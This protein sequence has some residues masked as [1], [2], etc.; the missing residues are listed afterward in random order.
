[1]CKCHHK[2]SAV[3][4]GMSKKTLEIQEKTLFDN[5]LFKALFKLFFKIWFKLSGWSVTESNPSSAGITIAAPHTSNW[6][7]F[8]AL[9]AAVLIDV[10]IYFSI[11]ESWCR[12]PVVGGLILWLGGIPI[13]RSAGSKG[14]VEKI[15]GF[16]DAHKDSRIFF[17]F[18]PEG[19]RGKVKGW[20]S[21][22]YH[23]A[24]ACDL[25]VFLAKVDFRLKE[26]GVFHSY[27]LT[28]DKE[29]DMRAMQESYKKVCGCFPDDQYPVY[30]GPLPEISD[31]EALILEGIHSMKGFVTLMEI[32]AQTKR[33]ELS[34]AMLEFLVE[35]G[36]LEQ[37]DNTDGEPTY[38]L[39][40]AGEGCLL[41]LFPTLKLETQ[42]AV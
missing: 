38:Q 22:F 1:M 16:V 24:E 14:Q 17:L 31:V 39:S 20:K 35:K 6:D 7:I 32:E 12:T 4:I 28:G 5:F 3:G 21:G 9:G 18:T 23:M 19:T 37:V 40:F 2:Y 30:T 34:A 41:H 26:A 36:V 27:H 25:P 15:R 8:Y 29:A 42:L 11:K 33:D 13:D 10:K